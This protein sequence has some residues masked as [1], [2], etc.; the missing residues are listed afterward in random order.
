[1]QQH[2]QSSDSAI[3]RPEGEELTDEE[4]KT[5]HEAIHNSTISSVTIKGSE[6]EITTNDG[7]CRFVRIGEIVYIEQN[8]D[9]K[10]KYAKMALEGRKITWITHKGKWGLIV[11]DEIKR[12]M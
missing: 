9:K 1:M 6:Y 11:D 3:V 10:T 8:K 5:I 7:A 12:S 2:L 4:L